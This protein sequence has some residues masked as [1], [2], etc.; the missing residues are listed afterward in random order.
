VRPSGPEQQWAELWCVSDSS[1]V[2]A[3]GNAPQL[4]GHGLAANE[5]RAVCQAFAVMVSSLAPCRMHMIR[6][7]THGPSCHTH[8][9]THTKHSRT[10]THIYTHLHTRLH[11]YLH[12]RAR[13]RAH[14]HTHTRRCGPHSMVSCRMM[15]SSGRLSGDAG[16]PVLRRLR[17]MHACGHEQ[18]GAAVL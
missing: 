6:A 3:W 8:T 18:A 14:T 17:R 11:A 7:H 4:A 10:H 15:R 2:L 9:Y 16:S 1:G 12:T 13:A 5:A